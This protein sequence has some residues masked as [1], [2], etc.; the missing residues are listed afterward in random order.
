MQK[1]PNYKFIVAFTEGKKV[2]FKYSKSGNWFR[3]DRLSQFEEYE[4]FRIKQKTRMI[5]GFEVP[6]A[7]DKEPEHCQEYFMPRLDVD[8][9]YITSFYNCGWDEKNFKR[10]ICF[11]NKEDAIAVAKAM[12]GIDP[13]S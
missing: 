12:L 6:C 10:G 13:N 8:D 2:Q 3:V 4:F 11:T 7:M 1:H 5:N 9:F